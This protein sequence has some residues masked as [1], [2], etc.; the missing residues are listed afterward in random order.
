MGTGHDRIT[1]SPNIRFGKPCI[2][3][4]RISVSDI[5]VWT[6]RQ[7]RSVDEIC[8]DFQLTSADVHAA[9]AYYFEHRQEIDA[10]LERQRQLDEEFAR[11]HPSILKRRAPQ[12]DNG[13]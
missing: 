1:I 3:G 11:T 10:D 12:E 4:R 2:A 9:L 7:G 8:E 6:Q 5:A 13:G